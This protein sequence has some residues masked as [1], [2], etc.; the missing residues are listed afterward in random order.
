MSRVKQILHLTDGIAQYDAAMYDN[1]DECLP[2]R[3]V[4]HSK[5]GKTVYI[6]LGDPSSAYAIPP[7]RI[8]RGN[9]VYAILSE[10][11]PFEGMALAGSWYAGGQISMLRDLG[12]PAIAALPPNLSGT[13]HLRGKVSTL[14]N[15]NIQGADNE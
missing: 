6:K 3:L 10:S 4:G 12:I 15:I 7:V 2:P 1:P 9:A 11:N 14:S 13:A 8:R 5:D